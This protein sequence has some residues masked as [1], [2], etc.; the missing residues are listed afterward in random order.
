ME[1]LFPH[2]HARYQQMKQQLFVQMRALLARMA[3]LEEHSALTP[4]LLEQPFAFRMDLDDA[5]LCMNGVIDRIDAGAHM[6]VILDYKSS[7]KTLSETKVYSG[8]QLQL[9]VYALALNSGMIPRSEAIID[10][11][12]VFYLSMRQEAITQEALK[13][14]RVKKTCEPVSEDDVH[15]QL[16]KAHRL[17]GW[18]FS[19][20]ISAFDDTG[21]HVAGLK[22][23][24]E[25]NVVLHNPKQTLHALPALEE[26]MKL[27]LA[28]LARRILSG[29][30]E[31]EPD[32]D[33]C[34][35]CDFHSI[36]RYHGQPYV[37]EAIITREGTYAERKEDAHA[38]VE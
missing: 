8:R 36:C 19:E 27:L 25:G 6:G 34:V 20:N 16:E 10:V 7:R 28:W 9:P 29:A 35:Y 18:I 5:Q 14:S 26:G 22:Q 21:T 13:I 1:R 30:I 4:L 2:R 11:M 38:K 24:K 33:A 32:E 12:G 15:A 31:C 17:N 3:A 23:D 37:K